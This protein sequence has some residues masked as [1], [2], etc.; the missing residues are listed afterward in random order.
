MV[1]SAEQSLNIFV[2]YKSKDQAIAERFK[3]L[4][5]GV[6]IPDKRELLDVFISNGI[7]KGEDWEKSIHEALRKCDCFILLY[8]DPMLEWSW[9]LYESGF[10]TGKRLDDGKLNR[11]YIIFHSPDTERLSGNFSVSS[12]Q[13]HAASLR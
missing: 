4:L 5:Y 6:L 13:A 2:S 3:T 1:N 9:C 10:Y 11:K 7:P 12:P 8:T